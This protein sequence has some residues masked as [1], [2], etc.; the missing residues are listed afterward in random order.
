MSALS[1]T[2]IVM[3]HILSFQQ[4]QATLNHYLWLYEAA[5][6]QIGTHR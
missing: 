2:Y 4:K 1:I 5:V 6:L 3:C